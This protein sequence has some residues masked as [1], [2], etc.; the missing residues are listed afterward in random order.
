MGQIESKDDQKLGDDLPSFKP[1]DVDTY[2]RSS[3]RN[4]RT[5]YNRLVYKIGKCMGHHL[6]YPVSPRVFYTKFFEFIYQ[7]SYQHFLL[8]LHD[9]EIDIYDLSLETLGF[10]PNN[11]PDLDP[12][13]DK[14]RLTLHEVDAI[15]KQIPYSDIIIGIFQ[16]YAP[17]TIPELQKHGNYDALQSYIDVI[18][19]VSL[20]RGTDL[21]FERPDT[22]GIIEDHGWDDFY[23]MSFGIIPFIVDVYMNPKWKVPYDSLYIM[24]LYMYNKYCNVAEYDINF[25]REPYD[26][27]NAASSL[28]K[29]PK[30]SKTLEPLY[31]KYKSLM[32]NNLLRKIEQYV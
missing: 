29:T 11:L 9:F 6:D 8:L 22:Q 25:I 28:L 20:E 24:L 4:Q 3:E 5:W 21:H 7:H 18:K 23:E 14:H 2:L 31:K 30:T 32:N 1:I 16:K 13:N 17:N 12:E 19:L 27:S 26:T 15:K 10:D